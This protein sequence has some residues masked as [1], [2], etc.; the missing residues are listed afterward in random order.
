MFQG[1]RFVPV[2]SALRA[3]S[4]CLKSLLRARAS[5]SVFLRRRQ[6][7]AG[8]DISVIVLKVICNAYDG[9]SP[10]IGE[11]LQSSSPLDVTF[12]PTHPGVDRLFHWKRI[13]TVRSQLSPTRQLS[14]PLSVLM[15]VQTKAC[16]GTLLRLDF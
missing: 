5:A 12:W 7:S 15:P 10:V 14:N 16:T 11:S 8:N 4:V 13:A 9:L 2:P 6:D 3:W 1:V